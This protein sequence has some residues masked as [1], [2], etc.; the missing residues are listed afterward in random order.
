MKFKRKHKSYLPDI[1]STKLLPIIKTIRQRQA[2]KEIEEVFKE[3]C[4]YFQMFEKDL[5]DTYEKLE[6]E[7]EKVRVDREILREDCCEIKKKVPLFVQELEKLK[8]S[9]VVFEEKGRKGT[10]QIDL[11]G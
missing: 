10:S 4:R 3:K 7:L 1:N 11:T 8:E 6:K 5:A 2:N 9:L